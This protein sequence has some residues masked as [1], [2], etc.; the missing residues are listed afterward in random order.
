M[1]EF[2]LKK[3]SFKVSLLLLLLSIVSGVFLLRL[4]NY[5]SEK[6]DR[7]FYYTDKF[8]PIKLPK[9]IMKAE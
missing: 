3:K 8:K 5:T 7:F 9:K 1:G 6:I 2:F 4:E